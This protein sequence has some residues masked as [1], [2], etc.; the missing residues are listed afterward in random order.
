MLMIDIDRFKN[1]NDTLGHGMGDALLKVAGARLKSC[2]RDCDTLARWGGDEFVLLLPGLQDSTTSVTVAQRCLS[3]LKEPFVVDGQALHV[4]ASIGISLSL[5][6]SM[7]AETLLKNADTAMYKAKA[8]GGDCYVIYSADMSAGA[9]NRLS[10]ENA[11]FHAIERNE[12]LLHYQ[13]FVSA[14]TGRL[15]GVEALLRWQHPD[16]GL[17]SPAQFIPIAEETGLIDSIG[18]WVLRG[19]CQ[20]MDRWYLSGL[21]RIA[22]SVNVSSRQFRKSTLASTIKAVLDDTRFDPKLLELELTESVLM[23]DIEGSRTILSELKA[24]GVSIA[25]DDFGTGYSSLSYLKGFHLDSLKIDRTFIA[26]ITTSEA[27]ASIVRATIGLGKGL[28]LRTIAEGVETR[29]QADY[30]VAQGCDVLQ[31]F[32]FARPM[33]PAAF[34]S[35]A[36]AAHTYLLSRPSHDEAKIG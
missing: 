24:L 13:P 20:Q 30:L 36:T 2:I 10:M 21:P 28:R 15:A 26:E 1:I 17:V 34:L 4:T 5:D 9:R 16:Y 8:R 33:E 3:A 14:R 35:F 27:T 11:L 23:D 7:E 31:G 22:I 6:A 32:L 18:E 12:L 25:L 19:A 29:G